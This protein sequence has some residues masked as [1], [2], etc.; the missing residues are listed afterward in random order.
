MLLVYLL[1][2]R[3]CVF[4]FKGKLR[5]SLQ[6]TKVIYY[7]FGT[8]NLYIHCGDNVCDFML[9]SILLLTLAPLLTSASQYVV[10]LHFGGWQDI[11]V[12]CTVRYTVPDANF[13]KT[14]IASWPNDRTS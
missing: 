3:G 2:V 7:S 8:L 1:K 11:I 5:I 12:F 10:M 13:L 14:H 6:N 4:K 9:A